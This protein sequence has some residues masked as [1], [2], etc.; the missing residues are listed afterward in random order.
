MIEGR[1]ERLK[2]EKEKEREKD[3]SVILSQADIASRANSGS[4]AMIYRPL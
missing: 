2:R 1:G 3:Q 4:F